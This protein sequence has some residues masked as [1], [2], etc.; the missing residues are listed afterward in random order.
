[1]RGEGI[2]FWLPVAFA[3]VFALY[4]SQ[5]LLR[6][7]FNEEIAEPN[8][9][10]EREVPACRGSIFDSTG[11]VS[12]LVKSVPC[13]EYRLDPVALTNRSVR[14]KMKGRDG[15]Y[16]GKRTREA[17]CGTIAR[18]LGLDYAKVLAMSR[19][20]A[21]RYQ[22]LA[23]SSDQGAH[24]ILK[25]P[26]L[27]SGVAI[28][29]RQIRQY[30]HNRRLC[31][32]IGAINKEGVGSAGL[33]LKYDK[34]LSGVPGRIRGCRDARG[35]ELY[36]KRIET[37]KP[38][39]GADIRLTID[40]N[41][42]YEAETALAAG[43]KEYGAA[44]GWCVVLDA[45]TGA[46]L[47]LAS[48]PDFNPLSF[49][50]ASDSAKLNRVT[51]ITYEPGSV[52]KVIT[53]AAALEAGIATPNTLYSTKRADERYYRL[54][55]DGSHVWE[56]FMSVR[57]AIVHSSNIVIGKLGCDL[58]P[59]RL[60]TAMDKFGFGSKT[61]IEIP[62]EEAGILPPWRKWDKVKWSRAPIG[63]GVAVT[64]IQLAS[65]YQAIANDGVRM[66]PHLVSRITA[67]DGHDIVSNVP[68]VVSRPI[69]RST[70]RRVRQMMLGV[71]SREG[72]ARRAAIRGYSVAGKTG[73]AQK[74]V[75]GKYSDHLY[76]ATF[77]GI[78]PSGVVMRSEGDRAPQPPRFVALV[79][80]DFEQRTKYHQGGNS[81]APIFRR[82]ATAALRYL[83][84]EPDRPDE[85]LEFEDDDEFDRIMDERAA[86]IETD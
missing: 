40:H 7:H 26:R 80:L 25:N 52:M 34:Y 6:T 51:S 68:A 74:V 35:N 3:S 38:V 81:A 69:S 18:A 73:T 54:P 70:S 43:I 77:C 27:V 86:A 14:T 79:T 8:Y 49:G 71:A 60:W 16:A 13:W 29:D 22:Y 37:V 48:Y 62:G 5:K 33:E 15:K 64:A 59:E 30:F 46:V 82:I 47:A 11:R 72:T 58:G 45:K 23:Q 67:A 9:E 61:G 4:T 57:D 56:P 17:I 41:L 39:P 50:R 28:E 1:M 36:D 31:H 44:T 75:N 42:Q 12:P 85:L 21:K 2:R 66:R 24:D 19:N 55:G 83:E 63:Q 65:A 76:R 10:F 78:V 84:V 53:A 20:P 32:V